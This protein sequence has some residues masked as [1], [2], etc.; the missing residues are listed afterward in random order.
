PGGVVPGT[1]TICLQSGA[2][3]N[4][5][6]KWIVAIGVLLLPLRAHALLATCTVAVSGGGIAFG[7]YAS[8]GTAHSDGSSTVTVTC[9][10]LGVLVSYTI[11]MGPGNGNYANR[12]LMSGANFLN[13]NMYTNIARTVVWGDGSAGTQ[14]VSHSYL[15][16]L[17]NVTHNYN[18]FGRIPGN[19]NQPAGTY[20]DS[21]TVTVTY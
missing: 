16:G 10:G 21:V 3:M 15:I 19:Q 4:H 1:G 14:T 11:A 12:K 18:V 9:S 5:C 8:P 2:R 17:G 13:Y 6:L 7:T 20:T